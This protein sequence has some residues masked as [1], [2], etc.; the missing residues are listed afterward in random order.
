MP[1]PFYTESNTPIGEVQY[2]LGFTQKKELF[3]GKRFLTPT[4]NALLNASCKWVQL[5]I[6]P[7]IQQVF[8]AHTCIKWLSTATQSW[9]KGNHVPIFSAWRMIPPHCKYWYHP[10][11]LGGKRKT[12]I[13][14][15]S[16]NMYMCIHTFICTL[17]K[18]Y[19]TNVR[20]YLKIIFIYYIYIYINISKNVCFIAQVCVMVFF[21]HAKP[22]HDFPAK[23]LGMDPEFPL[24]FLRKTTHH[25]AFLVP[26]FQSFRKDLYIYTI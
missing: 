9:E 11:I 12:N 14:Y 2:F 17:F 18:V 22:R 21:L 1:E 26:G 13:T 8:G 5:G 10:K 16:I 23:Y 24:S 4:N 3:W 7:R 20:W 19:K 15:V 6:N 25:H